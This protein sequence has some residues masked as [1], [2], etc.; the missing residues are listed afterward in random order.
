ML[1]TNLFVGGVAQHPGEDDVAL[2]VLR[3]VS[4]TVYLE[5]LFLSRDTV[6]EERGI[7][8]GV[9]L[10]VC[11]LVLLPGLELVNEGVEFHLELGF[12]DLLVHRLDYILLLPV[13]PLDRSRPL[14]PTDAWKPNQLLQ[15]WVIHRLK[16][17]RLCHYPLD[18][19]SGKISRQMPNH[20]VKC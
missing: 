17:Q 12:I 8:L 11:L 10:L 16:E 18:V 6:L 20:A 4:A 13:L 15:F 1:V 3:L 14:D 7:G 9:T 2:L 19:V 5:G